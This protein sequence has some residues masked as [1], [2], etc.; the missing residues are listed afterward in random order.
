MKWP[1]PHADMAGREDARINLGVT[2]Q[3][4]SF[5][6]WGEGQD[7]G[8]LGRLQRDNISRHDITARQGHGKPPPI[9]KVPEN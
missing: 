3:Q 5:S 2:D 7:E 9:K 6:P 4:R 1:Y 8:V